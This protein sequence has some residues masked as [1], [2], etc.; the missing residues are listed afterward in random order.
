M[1]GIQS[2]PQGFVQGWRFVMG[3][4]TDAPE[5]PQTELI[6]GKTPDQSGLAKG[7]EVGIDTKQAANRPRH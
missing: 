1:A 4:K 6:E 5:I 2:F 3:E 7:L